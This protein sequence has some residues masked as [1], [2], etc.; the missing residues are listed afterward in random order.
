MSL[1]I[2]DNQKE[3]L[4]I[5]DN[6]KIFKLLITVLIF[7]SACRAFNESSDQP[8]LDSVRWQL[9]A[10]NKQAA[11]LGDKAF[12]MLNDKDRKMTGKAACNSIFASYEINGNKINFG[13][14][15]STMIYCEGL[16]DQESQIVTNLQKVKRFEIK[17]G[18]LYLY[19]S[20]D[21]LLTFKKVNTDNN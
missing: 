5:S 13:N 3:H 10:M 6:M 17:Y 21:L 2:F 12:I 11:D 1:S 19:S 9:L 15:G 20:D 18:L 4:K 7:S 8:K 16:M 14:I